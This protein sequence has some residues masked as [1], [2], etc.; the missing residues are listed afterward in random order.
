MDIHTLNDLLA[1]MSE[2]GNKYFEFIRV[3]ALSVGVY[4]LEA[5]AK[6]EQ[7]PHSEDEVYYVIKGQAKFDRAGKVQEVRPGSILFVQRGVEHRFLD[8]TRELVLLIRER[9]PGVRILNNDDHFI[10]E[11]LTRFFK[12]HHDHL[13]VNL[14]A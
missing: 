10:A 2:K 7:R 4:R 13:H 9:H 6:D 5:G 1:Q 14:P 11:G 8:I 12:G 3:P